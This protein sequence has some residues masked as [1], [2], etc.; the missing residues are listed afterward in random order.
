MDYLAFATD[1]AREQFPLVQI[2]VVRHGDDVVVKTIGPLTPRKAD[3][4]DAG[5]QHNLNHDDYYTRIVPAKG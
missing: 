1:T 3:R 4:V 5:M 2:E